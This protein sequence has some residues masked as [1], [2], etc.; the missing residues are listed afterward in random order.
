MNYQDIVLE[1]MLITED[2]YKATDCRKH[3]FEL[4][5]LVWMLSAHYDEN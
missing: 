5:R 2:F 3:N 1:V 4:L